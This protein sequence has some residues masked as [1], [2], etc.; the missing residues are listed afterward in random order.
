MKYKVSIFNKKQ[1]LFHDG[2][3]LLLA[4]SGG[5]DSMVLLGFF[6]KEQV[7]IEVA[8]CNFG[9]RGEES[10]ED[11]KLVERICKTKNIAFHSTRFDTNKY[12]QEYKLSIQEAARDLRY[13]WLEKIRQEENCK[14]ILTAHHL[15]DNIETL[16]YNLTKGTGITGVRG[17]LPKN[18]KI[19]RPFLTVSRENILLYAK[20][21]DVN[22]REDSSNASTKYNRNKI[23]HKVIP[24]LQE[25][26]P[27]L[28]KTMQ[29][30]FER[31]SSINA[32]YNTA[33]SRL[34]KDV[35]EDRN[36]DKYIA[37]RKLCKIEG[38]SSLLFE[39]VRKYGFN[40]HQVE[41][42]AAAMNNA[43][44]KVFNTDNY[45]IIKDRNHLILTS[46]E[47]N[48]GTIF[49]I[50]EK[51]KKVHLPKG[52]LLKV[53]LKPKEKL[54]R[55]SKQSK[56]AYLDADKLDF[57]LVVRTWSQGD[58]FYPYG[59]YNEKG[60]AKKKKISQFFKDQKMSLIDKENTWLLTSGEKVVAVLGY[61]SDDRY[62]V[63][64]NT[65]NVLQLE[66]IGNSK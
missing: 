25:I 21:N 50:N 22:Y 64:D 37:I 53:H 15:D 41:D 33:I 34:E 35:I 27:N 7:D 54:T 59:F 18:G 30:H 51:T 17:M 39:I 43:E 24:I 42:I 55:M 48:E 65:K 1:S 44:T 38:Y 63:T 19:I 26:N 14:Y 29:A 62:K 66:L 2:D 49:S 12:A 56:Y 10:D 9:L 3:K 16:L 52:N 31:F 11:E 58:Y 6:A 57:P 23:R 61:R 60:K 36:G 13:E 32:L 47:N 20:E 5:L 45:R 28:E 40:Q 46:I 8:H 4:V